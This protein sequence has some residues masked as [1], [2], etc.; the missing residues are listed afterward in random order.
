MIEIGGEHFVR[1]DRPVAEVTILGDDGE[2][3]MSSPVMVP[4]DPSETTDVE[5]TRQAVELYDLYDDFQ[6]G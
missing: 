6:V 1:R 4:A 2:P 3:L 5:A